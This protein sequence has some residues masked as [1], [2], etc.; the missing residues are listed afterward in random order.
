[1]SFG[2]SVGD[3]IAGANLSYQLIQALSGVH[4][5]SEEYREALIE[6]GCLQQTFLQVGR[7]TSNPNMSPA[8]INAASHIVL[9]SMTLIG[10]FLT[11]TQKY[12]E[13]LSGRDQGSAAADS[14]RKVGWVMFR[15]DELKALKDAL[16]LKLT[17]VSLLLDTAQF[18]EKTPREVSVHPVELP[19]GVSLDETTDRSMSVSKERDAELDPPSVERKQGTRVPDELDK[20]MSNIDRPT[21]D[22]DNPMDDSVK[23]LQ[24]TSQHLTA[25]SGL[26]SLKG[27]KQL[28]PPIPPQTRKQIS[29]IRTVD[30]TPS[31]TLDEDFCRK[32]LTTYRAY[33]M[34]KVAPVDAREKATWA[35]AEIIDEQLSQDDIVVSLKRLSKNNSAQ[36]ARTVKDK[37]AALAPFQHGQVTQLV[38]QLRNDEDDPNFAW[39]IVQ[40][41]RKEAPVAHGKYETKTLTVYVKRAPLEGINPIL[42][43]QAWEK[44]GGTDIMPRPIP[45]PHAAISKSVIK[46]SRQPRLSK[47][48]RQFKPSN[49]TSNPTS[50]LESPSNVRSGSSSDADCIDIDTPPSS[51]DGNSFSA[52]NEDDSG[53]R[54]C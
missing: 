48:P 32:K 22:D 33:T 35:R 38:D 19:L 25:S 41:D 45:A 3:F 37:L 52:V 21:K 17:S 5:P 11:R 46:P 14:W 13:R 47:A 49:V 54:S 50:P 8:T 26:P 51:L 15:K 16:H 31:R 39:T 30:I 6:L 43:Y 12:R 1:M 18:Y 36:T 23:R 2:Y 9:S 44:G 27:E 34:R 10:D 4:C 7:M 20:S 40:L 24:S 28:G 53:S 29:S 42:L